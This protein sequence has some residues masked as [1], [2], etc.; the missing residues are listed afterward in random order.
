VSPPAVGAAAP[1]GHPRRAERSLWIVLGVGI[2]L[3]LA[4]AVTSGGSNMLLGAFVLGLAVVAYQRVLLAWPTL[5]ALILVVILFIPIR[6]YTVGGSLPIELE[7][8]RIVIAL[9]LMCW[10]CAL[11]ADPNVRWRRTGLEGPIA[12]LLLVIL[13]SLAA[14]IGRVNAASEIVVKQVSFFVSY[15]VVVYFVVSVMRSRR[16]VDRMLRVL[17]GGATVVAVLA[18]IEWRTGGNLFNW[19]SRVF[20]FLDYVDEGLPPVRG[21]GVRARG[22]AQ[23]SIALGAALVMMIPLAVYLFRRDRRNLWLYCAGLLT[24]GALSTGSRTGTLMLISLL[25]SFVWIKPRETVRLLPMLLPL[26]V[27]IQVAMPGTLGTMKSLLNPSY[28][29]KEQSYD[30]GGGAGRVADLGPALERWSRQPFL[31][32]GFGTKVADPNAEANSD[33]QILDNQWLGSLLEIGAFGVLALLWLYIRAI[34][35]LAA[36]ARSD[37]GDDGW[38]AMGLAAALIALAV[39]MLTFDAFAFVQ[40]TFFSFILL[41]FAAT[42]VVADGARPLPRPSRQAALN[43]LR[44]AFASR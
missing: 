10:F 44:G 26:L 5:L 13:L 22:S 35:R 42:T 25:V 1:P 3:V 16:D 30:E 9:V 28:V 33:Q 43:P 14:N 17:V 8:Y 19:Y 36:R 11:A 18:L 31:G 24:L 7:P 23:H 4:A 38:L 32:S 15:F 2:A 37:T 20:P 12:A 39:G 29:I 6:R 41:G 27:V 34:R 21:S 40:V